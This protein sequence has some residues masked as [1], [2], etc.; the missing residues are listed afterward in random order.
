MVYGLPATW[1]PDIETIIAQE[2][3]QL[4]KQAG[5]TLAISKVN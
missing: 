1:K 3:L 5:A 2:V 4:V